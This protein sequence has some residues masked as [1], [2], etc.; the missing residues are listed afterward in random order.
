MAKKSF[1]ESASHLD[2]FFTTDETQEP[3]QAQV[4]QEPEQTQEPR[5]TL[6]TQKTQRTRKVQRTDETHEPD[7]THETQIPHRTQKPEQTH[8]TQTTHEPQAA[9]PVSTQYYRLNLKLKAEYK[10]Y[11]ADAAWERRQSITE[12]L[13]QLIERDKATRDTTAI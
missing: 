6:E 7:G 10:E 5:R 9:S 12:Y 3:E 8:E 1:K 4:T 11:L 2:R 13:N